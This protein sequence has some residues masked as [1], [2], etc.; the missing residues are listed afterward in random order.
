MKKDLEVISSKFW[1][2]CLVLLFCFLLLSA[3]LIPWNQNSRVQ[4]LVNSHAAKKRKTKCP[5]SFRFVRRL[6][7]PPLYKRCHFGL[8]TQSLWPWGW[9]IVNTEK[10]THKTTH[11]DK[12][13]RCLSS[14]FPGDNPCPKDTKK[15]SGTSASFPRPFCIYLKD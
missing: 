9:P 10:L 11:L 2:C 14:N 15:S 8:S 6:L 3:F 4:N 1:L 13:L 5:S 7:K 12:W